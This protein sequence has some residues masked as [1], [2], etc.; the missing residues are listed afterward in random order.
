MPSPSTNQTSAGVRD[1]SDSR[2]HYRTSGMVETETIKAA[3][4]EAGNAIPFNTLPIIPPEVVEKA[5]VPVAIA[6]PGLN[7]SGFSPQEQSAV[8]KVRDSFA[9]SIAAAPSQDP[10]SPAYF[11]YWKSAAYLHDEQLRITLGWDSFNRLSALAAQAAE[12]AR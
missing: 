7:L 5:P 9:V 2:P 4:H 8:Q 1:M 6:V 10:D 11:G 12:S 3:S